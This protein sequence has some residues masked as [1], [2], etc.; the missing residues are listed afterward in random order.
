MAARRF[1]L[2]EPPL[3]DAAFFAPACGD[4]TGL[5]ASE[6]TVPP[7]SV[8]EVCGQVVENREQMTGHQ[9]PPRSDLS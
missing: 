7:I 1:G 6:T 8:S 2:M 5:A 9:V 4:A 3:R